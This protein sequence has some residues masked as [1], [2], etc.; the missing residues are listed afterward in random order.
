[1]KKDLAFEISLAVR[2]EREEDARASFAKLEE[3]KDDADF[4][5]VLQDALLA[6]IRRQRSELAGEWLDA[7]WAR[8]KPL[9]MLPQ[10]LGRT[11]ELLQALC[12]A[13]CD[14]RLLVLAPRLTR[15][16]HAW[17]SAHII[18]PEALRFSSELLSLAARLARRGWREET[19]FLLR[20]LIWSAVRNPQPAFW[21]SLLADFSLHFTVYARWESFVRACKAYPELLDVYLL[22]LR[23]AGRAQGEREQLLLLLL[24]SIRDLLANVARAT[25]QEEMEVF[26]QWYQYLWQVGAEQPKRKQ[27]LLM[28]LQLAI[29]YWQGTRPKTSKKQLSFLED[30]LNPNLVTEGYEELLQRII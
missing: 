20:F 1:M 30:L 7:S 14:R 26:R 3:L 9:L 22:L 16:L 27:Q 4:L 15:L 8:L 18:Q 29:R 6:A 17:M 10:E 11:A 5:Y 23:R 21:R 25:M 24:R 28:L 13:V 2:Q 19:R 12:F